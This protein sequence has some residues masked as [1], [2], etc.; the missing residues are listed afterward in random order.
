MTR[1]NVAIV[2]SGNIGTPPLAMHDTVLCLCDDAD[3]DAIRASVRDMVAQVAEYVPGY[4]L[5]HDVQIEQISAN[6]PMVQA[7]YD[8]RVS[9]LKF[10]VFLEVEGAAHYLPSYA[11][12]LDIMTSAALRTAEHILAKDDAR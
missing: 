1:K 9:G 4:R 11:G 3:Q 10:T 7:D 12:N 5:K 6:D 2:G 8:M